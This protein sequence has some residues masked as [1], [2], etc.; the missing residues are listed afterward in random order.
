MFR[1]I[2]ALVNLNEAEVMRL[3]HEKNDY[4]VDAMAIVAELQKAMEII[5]ERFKNKDYFLGELIISAR[6]FQKS[7]EIIEPRLRVIGEKEPLGKMVIATPKGDIH[8]VGKNIV[9]LLLKAA[10]FEIHDLGVDVPV[11]KLIDKVMEV[12]PQ[13][14]GFSALITTT[15][16][17]MREAVDKLKELGLRNQLRVIIGGGVTNETVRKYVGADAQVLDAVRG[18]EICKKFIEEM[19]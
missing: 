18:I 14:V 19:K 15:F 8:D 4:G 16:G 17:P 10:N 5:G 1:L 7:M 6:L 2:E 9:V 12:K 13:I 11:Q 3:V